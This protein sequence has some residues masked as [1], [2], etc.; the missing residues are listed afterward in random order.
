MRWL[1]TGLPISAVSY[2]SGFSYYMARHRCSG[3]IQC[4]PLEVSRINGTARVRD[5]M[6]RDEGL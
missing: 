4:W 1:D 6:V 2:I 3:V 5:L